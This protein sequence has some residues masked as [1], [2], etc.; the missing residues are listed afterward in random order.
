M[1]AELSN[2][3][4]PW[5]N[6]ISIQFYLNGFG[7]PFIPAHLTCHLRQQEQ[8]HSGPPKHLLIKM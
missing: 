5:W 1:H 2:A 8:I 7:L 6:Y 3:P 4:T